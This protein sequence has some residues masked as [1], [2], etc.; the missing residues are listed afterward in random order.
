[1]RVYKIALLSIVTMLAMVSCEP[2]ELTEVIF[3][4]HNLEFQVTVEN[5][6]A[7]FT[8]TGLM[9]VNMGANMLYLPPNAEIEHLMING[10]E[11]EFTTLDSNELNGV[12]P[13]LA[14]KIKALG[15]DNNALWVLFDQNTAQKV[16]FKISYSAVFDADVADAKFSN[17]NV[18]REITGTIIEKGAYF[19]PSSYY[20]P[21]GNDGL[22]RFKVRAG[23]Q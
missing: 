10:A 12:N 14:S 11:F 2:T 7:N 19:S 23:R 20:Y 21:R 5:H 22:M 18:G 8:D 9:Q 4:E 1:M 17:Q 6:S 3:L 13:E 15:P 16:T